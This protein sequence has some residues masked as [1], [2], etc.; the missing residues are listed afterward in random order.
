M[1]TPQE[2][3]E[4]GP[5][6]PREL[7][8]Q[9]YTSISDI[10]PIITAMKKMTPRAAELFLESQYSFFDQQTKHALLDFNKQWLEFDTQPTVNT[11][12]FVKNKFYATA[13]LCGASWGQ[14][15]KL[16]GVARTTV[17]SSTTTILDVQ[18]RQ[19]MRLVSTPISLERVSAILAAYQE[20]LTQEPGYI[21]NS[22]IVS[23]A[24]RIMGIADIE[25]NDLESAHDQAYFADESPIQQVAKPTAANELV[26][27]IVLPEAQEEDP[28][29]AGALG[30]AQ[31]AA[32][33]AML[34]GES[35][36]EPALPPENDDDEPSDADKQRYGL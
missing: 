31:L 23:I 20:L 25:M 26:D 36:P 3:M 30:D 9:Y 24:R 19:A 15:A 27:R 5:K 28:T 17:S 8:G 14:L 10:V 22:S 1:R 13:W 35:K 11:K 29:K 32:L 34:S 7:V 33:K 2:V 18:T 12:V 16:F 4:N 6:W 21:Y